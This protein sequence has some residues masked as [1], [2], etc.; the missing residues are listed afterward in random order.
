MVAQPDVADL[1]ESGECI[2]QL[3]FSYLIGDPE[4]VI[5]GTI[6][7]LVRQPDGSIVVL[8]LGAGAPS[9]DGTARLDLFVQVAREM[10]PGAHVS[11]R[12]VCAQ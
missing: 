1:L 10:F 7:G 5:R 3:P 9:A 6:D 11:G 8:A 12:L 4:R 2:R